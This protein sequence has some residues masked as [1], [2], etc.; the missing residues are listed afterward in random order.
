MKEHHTCSWTCYVE[1]HLPLIDIFKIRSKGLS[2][3]HTRESPGSSYLKKERLTEE[4]AKHSF[5]REFGG[6]YVHVPIF[7]AFRE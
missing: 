7:R 6:V 5:L 4:G 3:C 2:R 1:W